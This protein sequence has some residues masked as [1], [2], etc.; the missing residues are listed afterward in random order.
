MLR[1]RS[2]LQP[3]LARRDSRRT[4]RDDASTAASALGESEVDEAEAGAASDCSVF[5]EPLA[6]VEM[7]FAVAAVHVALCVAAEMTTTLCSL[8]EGAV[9]VVVPGLAVGLLVEHR[10]DCQPVVWIGDSLPAAVALFAVDRMGLTPVR[11]FEALI[12]FAA[13]SDS[14][15]RA[16]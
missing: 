2:E 14:S 6:L 16:S 9:V 1:L 5:G 11:H 12:W 10:V 8:R 7:R 13:W 15:S 3:R 4:A